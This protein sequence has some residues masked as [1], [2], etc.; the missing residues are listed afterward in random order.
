MGEPHERILV[1]HLLEH[2]IVGAGDGSV[3]GRLGLDHDRAGSD[4]AL[5]R[6]CFSAASHPGT[7]RHPASVQAIQSWRAS[8]TAMFRPAAMFAPGATTTRSGADPLPA[9]QLLEGPVRGA[10]VDDDDLV[11]HLGLRG[12][13]VQQLGQPRPVIAHGNDQ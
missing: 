8:R 4:V 1:V 7:G 3:E 6:A 11:R 2:G 10:A 12:E 9:A 5:A 13:C